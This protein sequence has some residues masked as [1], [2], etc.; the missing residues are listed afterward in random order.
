MQSVSQVTGEISKIL[1]NADTLK[2]SLFF[3]NF[4]EMETHIRLKK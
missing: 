3:C 1:Q 4:S 2:K